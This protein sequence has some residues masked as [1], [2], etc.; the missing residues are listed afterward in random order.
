MFPLALP[1]VT[2]VPLTVTVAFASA[3]VGVTVTLVVALETL[4]V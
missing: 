3:T 4:A 2:L 1:E